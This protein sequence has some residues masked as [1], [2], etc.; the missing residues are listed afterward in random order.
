MATAGCS[1]RAGLASGADHGCSECW[2]ERLIAAVGYQSVGE[3]AS[4]RVEVGVALCKLVC[5]RRT[6]YETGGE[7]GSRRAKPLNA[8]G[9]QLYIVPARVDHVGTDAVGLV[10]AVR[11]L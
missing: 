10:V 5:E 8:N 4:D 2:F 6:G 7:V 1:V 9:L 3:C 11:S